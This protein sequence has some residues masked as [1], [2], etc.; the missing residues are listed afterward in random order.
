[1]EMT[2]A[3]LAAVCKEHDLYRSAEL[4]DKLYCNFKGFKS[5]GP[6]LGDYSNLKVLFLEGNALEFLKG[7]PSLPSLRC[8]FPGRIY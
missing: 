2:K 7:M 8:L 3:A 1:M 4:N 6:A 5:I